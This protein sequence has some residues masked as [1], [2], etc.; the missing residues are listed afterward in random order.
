MSN[1]LHVVLG[2]RPDVAESWTD[3]EVA[4]RWIRLFPSIKPGRDAQ[5]RETLLSDALALTERR[6]R[7]CDL[8]WF[9]RCLDE[10]IA[11]RANAEDGVTG[12]FWEGRFKCQLLVSEQALAA[13]MVY[14]VLNPIRAG[15]AEGV[16]DSAHTSV[17]QRAEDLKVKPGATH[18]SLQPIAGVGTSVLAISSAQ[19]IELVDWSGRQLHPGKRGKINTTQPIALQTLGIQI[20][21]WEGQ[22]KGVGCGYWRV[23]GSAQELIDKAKTLGQQWFKGLGYARTL[24]AKA[25]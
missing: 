1:H 18:E 12:R 8:S 6:L 21:C 3:D 7:L 15:I 24:Y 2:I 19:Y 5:R 22:V 25:G 23:I 9:M 14:V 16:L 13:A 4:E 20:L 11:R 17:Q 10:H